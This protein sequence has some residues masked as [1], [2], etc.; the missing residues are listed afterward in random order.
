MYIKHVIFQSTRPSRASTSTRPSRASTRSRS[1]AGKAYEISIHKALAG[2]DATLFVALK[3]RNLFQSTRPS[4]ASTRLPWGKKIG[5]DISIH[6]ALA[7]L[8]YVDAEA[9]GR[10]SDF[11]PQGPRGPRHAGRTKKA[12]TV[13][14][15]STRPSRASTY[16]SRRTTPA[17]PYFNPQG[18]RGPRRRWI[19]RK[20]RRVPISIHKALAGLDP[21]RLMIFWQK[22][23]FQST[24]P[25]RASTHC[26][27]IALAIPGFQS[28]RPS[29]A[30]TTSWLSS[31]S[32]F[33][34][35]IHKAL[36]GLDL[37]SSIHGAI[38][39]DFN[40]QGPRGPRRKT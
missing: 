6:K 21:Y 19:A 26:S 10:Y 30:S 20:M 31:V 1:P 15:Q 40:P 12:Q 25:S 38:R 16:P 14:F 28:T 22:L 29:R 3:Y 4:R 8:D 17:Y 9:Y 32:G 23:Q 2:L 33:I 36:A 5:H 13:A 39:Q 18:P 37:P 24:R 7:G 35:S 34:I 11:N 27:A